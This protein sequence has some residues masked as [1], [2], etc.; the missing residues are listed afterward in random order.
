MTEFGW[1]CAV[2]LCA[3]YDRFTKVFVLWL[4]PFR[5]QCLIASILDLCLGEWKSIHEYFID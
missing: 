1:V 3:G 2:L 4:Y 5:A